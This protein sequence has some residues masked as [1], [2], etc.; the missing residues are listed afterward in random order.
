MQ[1]AVLYVIAMWYLPMALNTCVSFFFVGK[2]MM[3]TKVRRLY[4]DGPDI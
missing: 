3:M 1:F 4:R 2:R